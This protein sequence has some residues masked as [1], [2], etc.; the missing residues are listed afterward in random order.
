[1]EV[2][3]DLTDLKKE[4]GMSLRTKL[5]GGGGS[6][7]PSEVTYQDGQSPDYSGLLHEPEP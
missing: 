6:L 3:T 4:S 5:N 7:G 1:M 2:G